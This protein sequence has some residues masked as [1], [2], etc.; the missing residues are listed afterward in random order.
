[1]CTIRR[2]APP[3][4]AVEVLHGPAGARVDGLTTVPGTVRA[5]AADEGSCGPP[6]DGERDGVDGTRRPDPDEA[7]RTGDGDARTT[8]RRPLER[9]CRADT[10]RE[11]DP[12][13]VH[14][15]HTVGLVEHGDVVAERG[16]L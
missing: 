2:A 13:P 3:R 4:D 14:R 10:A 8:V 6:G 1:M 16:D 5:R 11:V 15:E 9:G 7:G 12:A